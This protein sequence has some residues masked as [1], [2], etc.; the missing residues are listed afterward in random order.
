MLLQYSRPIPE[1]N[2]SPT[3]QSLGEES[4]DS[5]SP[6]LASHVSSR[7]SLQEGDLLGA[8]RKGNQNP[9]IH[10][11]KGLGTTFDLYDSA[12]LEQAHREYV[13]TLNDQHH[14]VRVRQEL[15]TQQ[16]AQR[17]SVLS[18]Q[19]MKLHDALAQSQARANSNHS[20]KHSHRSPSPTHKPSKS[21][22][23]GPGKRTQSV[24][25][26]R[27][28]HRS[29][30][31]E[32]VGQIVT[33]T[34]NK[35]LP[36]LLGEA[37]KITFPHLLQSSAV[38]TPVEVA[39]AEGATSPSLAR[40]VQSAPPGDFQVPAV[41]VT[42]SATS[43]GGVGGSHGP[44]G[45]VQKG[46]TLPLSAAS[47]VRGKKSLVTHMSTV[48]EA[49]EQSSSASNPR[50][51]P[52]PLPTPQTSKTQ[53][54]PPKSNPNSY[55]SNAKPK[56]NTI[57]YKSKAIVQDTT[58]F[59]LSPGNP[60]IAPLAPTP[61]YHVPIGTKHEQSQY[62][63]PQNLARVDSWAQQD[64]LVN[65]GTIPPS[66]AASVKHNRTAA[67]NHTHLTEGGHSVTSSE[68]RANMVK[69]EELNALNE[70]LKRP[71]HSPPASARPKP[72][73]Q[74]NPVINPP[75]FNIYPPSVTQVSYA[76][77]APRKPSSKVVIPPL[78]QARHSNPPSHS[79]PPSSPPPKTSKKAKDSKQTSSGHSNKKT[80]CPPEPPAQGQAPAK[81]GKKQQKKNPSSHGS[82]SSSSSSTP[83]KDQNP[84][85]PPMAGGGEDAYTMLAKAILNL[86]DKPSKVHLD[87]F[88]M[89]YHCQLPHVRLDK[90]ERTTSTVVIKT[91][92][93]AR[94]VEAAAELA[95]SRK[96][97]SPEDWHSYFKFHLVHLDNALQE[98]M[99]EM[100]KEHPVQDP[101]VFWKMVFKVILPV[102]LS[103]PAC[104]QAMEEYMP[105]HE[106]VGILRWAAVLT[107]L[108]EHLSY[109]RH[110]RGMEK[111]LHIAETRY[112]HLQR[113]IQLCPLQPNMQLDTAFTAYQVDISTAMDKDEEITTSMYNAA[114]TAFI[115]YLTQ[116]WAKYSC[117]DTFGH[118][119][120]QGDIAPTQVPVTHTPPPLRATPSPPVSP[121]PAARASPAPPPPTYQQVVVEGGVGPGP[122]GQVRAFTPGPP[123]RKLSCREKHPIK[124]EPY[125]FPKVA[126]TGLTRTWPWKMYTCPNDPVKERWPCSYPPP[127][128][129]TDK[130][131]QHYGDW[132]DVQNVCTYCL[133]PDHKRPGCE[134]Y[135]LN[136]EKGTTRRKA[137]EAAKALG[138]QAQPQAAQVTGVP[139]N[140]ALVTPTQVMGN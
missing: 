78:K 49:R 61:T 5:N 126:P 68:A 1:G 28:T 89:N 123:G 92:V 2:K 132:L 40:S 73:P 116:K 24:A 107:A 35:S 76:N 41:Q 119:L 65:M 20:S 111:D 66:Q 58:N 9:Q 80:N 70:L 27:M 136:M 74:P 69:H 46:A 14:E 106:P 93:K 38:V 71:T 55:N 99:Q 128:D 33:D 72:R 114:S 84:A 100:L 60:I 57:T 95:A 121:K 85:P 15:E 31:K 37:F 117:F 8:A 120:V 17:N 4:D 140:S 67:S 3:R 63:T 96:P 131:C 79:S 109:L 105:W 103:I 81:S 110:K 118:R 44:P 36:A 102:H 112:H 83:S 139:S 13:Q 45:K 16:L 127:E 82:G 87:R 30:T 34:L 134:K 135:T 77:D 50:Q 19:N 133:S 91:F 23:I 39:P 98:E 42:K 108:L 22:K 94:A 51:N 97:V 56:Q 86:S 129:C 29:V 138:G 125:L 130:R 122:L 124:D 104:T 88:K 21:I 90:G 48:P 137:E 54:Q 18:E 43:V 10:P 101:K 11:S 62:L 7:S 47:L 12:K 32:E 113:M 52:P 59:P 64:A 25:S 6:P 53:L 115:K 75:A 26:S